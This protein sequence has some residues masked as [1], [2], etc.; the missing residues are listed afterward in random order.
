MTE[1]LHTGK[2]PGYE[3]LYFDMERNQ[4]AGGATSTVSK[5]RMPYLDALDYDEP[6]IFKGLA[7]LIP[8]RIYHA[9]RAGFASVRG[10]ESRRSTTSAC[11]P[12]KT[13]SP[14]S[15]RPAKDALINRHDYTTDELLHA[16][17][18]PVVKRLIELVRLRNTHPAFDGSLQVE[19]SNVKAPSIPP[20]AAPDTSCTLRVDLRT[21]QFSIDEGAD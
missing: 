14:R 8:I 16:F 6:G 9:D 2:V 5:V 12:A 17:N 3:N 1:L 10:E 15:R 7:Y 11:S 13:I 19:N 20:G 21:G 4:I 18:R